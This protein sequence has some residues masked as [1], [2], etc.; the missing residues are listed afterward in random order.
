MY[1]LELFLDTANLA[2][3]KAA[4]A[5]G[6]I[7]GV[8]TN[9]TL[10][11]REKGEFAD[12][13]AEIIKLI[14]GPVSAEVLAEDTEMML[15][16]ARQLAQIGANVVIKIPLTPAGVKCLPILAAEGIKT[17]VTLIFSL[18][19]ALLAAR[20]GAS[21]VSP[22]VG[23][24]D[25]IGCNGLSLVAQ[26]AEVYNYY[27]LPTKIIAASIRHPAH[28]EGAALAG[29]QIATLPYSVLQKMFAHPLTTIG[30]EQF[31]R[32]WQKGIK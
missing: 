22:F 8:T 13:V 10:V 23:R 15:S 28:V 24:L 11:A 3:I 26:I 17:N 27:Q 25:D 30:L 1:L 5:Y 21:F 20:A 14:P 7:S 31:A 6:V 32:D 16:E 9:P 18:N 2:E 29:A 4:A 12:L 19:Q